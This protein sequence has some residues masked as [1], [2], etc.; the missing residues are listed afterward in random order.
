MQ[1]EQQDG[2][3]QQQ[4]PPKVH[5]QMDIHSSKSMLCRNKLL[6]CISTPLKQNNQHLRPPALPSPL[7]TTNPNHST[8]Q[9][10]VFIIVYAI[11]VIVI[12]SIVI[13]IVVAAAVIVALPGQKEFVR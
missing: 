13:V 6:L 12:A 3:Q 4:Q 8:Y 2:Q 9:A 5:M 10:V 7:L 11:A 1:Q